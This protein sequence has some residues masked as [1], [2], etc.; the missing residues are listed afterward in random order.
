MT[1]ARHASPDPAEVHASSRWHCCAL[2]LSNFRAIV[3]LKSQSDPREAACFNRRDCLRIL[4]ARVICA[5]KVEQ[6][7][8]FVVAIKGGRTQRAYRSETRCSFAIASA[9]PAQRHCFC[10][11][12]LLLVLSSS[13]S[14]WHKSWRAR[15]EPIKQ[16]IYHVRDA[17]N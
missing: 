15:Q 13:H 1:D 6:N 7:E 11:S 4:S 9:Q 5:T 16:F 14:R 8:A 3:D 12:S 10:N 2:G 17:A